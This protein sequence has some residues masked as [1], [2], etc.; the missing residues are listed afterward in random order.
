MAKMNDYR[1]SDTAGSIIADIIEGEIKPLFKADRGMLITVIARDP[2]N[3]QA[4]IVIT[5]DDVDKVIEC[6]QTAK[7]PHRE[8]Q[9]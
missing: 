1:K 3:P 8:V 4:Y 5:R 9:V 6:L 7:T 2:N